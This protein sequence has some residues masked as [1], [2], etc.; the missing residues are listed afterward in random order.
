MTTYSGNIRVC[1]KKYL[2]ESHSKDLRRN[3]ML[4]MNLSSFYFITNP[5]SYKYLN[6]KI[7]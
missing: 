3:L 4:P 1:S 2:I 5:E 7:Q 6:P